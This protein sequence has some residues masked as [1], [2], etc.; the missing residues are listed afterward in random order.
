MLELQVY[1]TKHYDITIIY[2]TFV[3]NY[4]TLLELFLS[5]FI[6]HL[7]ISNYSIYFFNNISIFKFL[8]TINKRWIVLS[9][10]FSMAKII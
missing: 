8:F 10:F 9:M 2:T 3:P 7:R 6:R 5:L 4:T 1:A